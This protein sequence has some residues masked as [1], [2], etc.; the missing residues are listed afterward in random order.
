M[1]IALGGKNTG[2]RESFLLTNVERRSNLRSS[3]LLQVKLRN[4][5][6][7]LMKINNSAIQ[8]WHLGA[9]LV[10]VLVTE[11]QMLLRLDHPGYKLPMTNSSCILPP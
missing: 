1:W 4:L 2:A 6:T 8:H 3:R 10:T 9:L 11:P 7:P 5:R